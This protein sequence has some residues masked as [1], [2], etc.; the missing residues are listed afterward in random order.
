[1]VSYGSKRAMRAITAGFFFRCLASA[2]RS[3]NS[4]PFDL[5][6]QQLPPSFGHRVDIDSQK[7]R[8]LAVAALAY[9]VGLQ[10]GV[11]TPLPLIQQAVEQNDGGFQFRRRLRPQS[12]LLH[13]PSRR[14]SFA[15][16]ALFPLPR[17]SPG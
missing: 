14:P 12:R 15:P 13:F 6:A 1:A 10:A 11:E 8:D 3:A 4:L 2:S 17:R 9:F 7:L 16:Q 5:S